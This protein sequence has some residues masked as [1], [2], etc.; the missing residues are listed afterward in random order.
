MTSS[1][2]A[3]A[4]GHDPYCGPY[5]ARQKILRLT[6]PLP[7]TPAMLRGDLCEDACLRYAAMCN[8]Q[9]YGPL[10]VV[11]PELVVHAN[12]WSGDSCDA[13]YYDACGNLVALGEAKTDG[14][15]IGWGEP[16]TDQIPDRVLIQSCMHLYHYPQ[17]QQVWVPVLFGGFSF[18]FALYVVR[19]NQALIDDLMQ[20]AEAWHRRY[21]VGDEIPPVTSRDLCAL[22]DAWP[23]DME[24]EMAMTPELEA[25][26][27]KKAEYQ[28]ARKNICEQEDEA[29]AHIIN[30]M[31]DHGCVSSPR[32]KISY[33]NSTYTTTDWEALARHLG[34]T[35]EQIDAHIQVKKGARVLRV[36]LPKTKR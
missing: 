30:L 8:E 26:A 1:V 9:E 15:G 19:R 11:K 35:Q 31:Q 5:T 36:T 7:Q 16:G 32:V 29:K 13:L 14:T 10:K 34:A 4:L 18:Q 17:A 3:A 12:G 21:I 28:A 33:R 20:E 23:F 24:S 2:V 25:W 27:L 6:P 22:Q